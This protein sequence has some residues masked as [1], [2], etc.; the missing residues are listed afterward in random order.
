MQQAIDYYE[1]TVNEDIFSLVDLKIR[2]DVNKARKLMRSYARGISS[3]CSNDAILKDVSSNDSS[4]DAKTFQTYM[5]ALK[6][7]FVIEELEAW[8]PNLRSKVA[9]REKTQ[10][11]SLIRPLL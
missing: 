3:P 4:F 5:L 6:R 2:K 8:N 7:L 1:A 10:G 11:I 9:I